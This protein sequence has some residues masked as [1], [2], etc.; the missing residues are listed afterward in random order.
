MCAPLPFD[1]VPLAPVE[2]RSVAVAERGRE[3][4][5]TVKDRRLG[6]GAE[7]IDPPQKRDW[8]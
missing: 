6:L 5:M 3:Q 4:T 7:L 1:L 2:G 8:A